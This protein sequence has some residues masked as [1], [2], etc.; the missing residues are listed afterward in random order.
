MDCCS[1]IIKIKVRKCIKSHK[2]NDLQTN[3]QK[4]LCFE[5]FLV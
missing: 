2:P 3:F 5:E 1:G 4:E